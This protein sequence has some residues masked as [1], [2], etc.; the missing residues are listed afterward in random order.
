MESKIYWDKYEV[1]DDGRICSIDTGQEIHQS[2]NN[3]YLD[4]RLINPNTGKIQT[5]KVHRIVAEC[6][7]PRSLNKTHVLHKN[8]NKRDN[9]VSNLKWCT[10][11]ELNKHHFNARFK[12]VHKANKVRWSRPGEHERMSLL[13][14]E[15]YKDRDT[16][17]VNNPNYTYSFLYNGKEYSRIELE[18]ELGVSEEWIYRNKTRQRLSKPNELDKL[19]IAVITKRESQSTIEKK[20]LVDVEKYWSLQKRKERLL[21][22]V[23]GNMIT[24]GSARRLSRLNRKMVI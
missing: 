17:G 19:G 18:K 3:G 13:L 24:Q 10:S 12:S 16:T 6:F 11:K 20:T 4:V 14:K 1:F 2:P 5:L 22:R 23:L 15:K 7:I 21:S 8:H 9:K